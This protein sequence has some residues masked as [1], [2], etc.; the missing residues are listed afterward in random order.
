MVGALFQVAKGEITIDQ[1]DKL[2][3]EPD[4][5]DDFDR[6]KAPGRGLTLVGIFFKE[7]SLHD[8][9]IG[10]PPKDRHAKKTKK[11]DS[12]GSGESGGELELDD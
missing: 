7:G 6:F 1:F 3:S 5:K 9:P 11:A 8:A 4:V 12:E 10:C 2:L